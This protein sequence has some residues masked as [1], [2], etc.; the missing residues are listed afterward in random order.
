MREF[1]KTKK[2]NASDHNHDT[3]TKINCFKQN[4]HEKL[5]RKISIISVTLTNIK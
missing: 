1:I 3:P 2:D 4:F 5:K